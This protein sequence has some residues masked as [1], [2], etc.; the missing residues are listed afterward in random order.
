M[1]I[2]F[3]IL[4]EVSQLPSEATM[5]EHQVTA[6]SEY[7]IVLE[8]T[9]CHIRALQH[10]QRKLE[11]KRGDKTWRAIRRGIGAAGDRA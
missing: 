1:S 9:L 10:Y 7:L 2:L 5:P 8:V 6:T 3:L 11:L 4:Y